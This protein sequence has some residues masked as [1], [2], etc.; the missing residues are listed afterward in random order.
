[1]IW[2]DKEKQTVDAYETVRAKGY[3]HPEEIKG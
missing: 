3:D 1:M 2:W